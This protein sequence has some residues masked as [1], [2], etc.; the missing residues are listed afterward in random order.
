M[1]NKRV[2]LLSEGFGTGH[3]Q[4]ARALA[5]SLDAYS[6]QIET[7]VLELG[8]HQH[9]VIGP[10]ILNTYRLT[11]MSQPKLIGKLYHAKYDNS[12]GPLTQLALHRV[13]Y[14]R[15][16]RIIEEQRPD[17][18]VCTH[19]FPNMIVSRLKKAGLRVPLCTAITDYDAH[20]TWL[21]SETDAYLV[22]TEEVRKTML[23]RGVRDE[24][25][26][27]TGIPVH[28]KFH[29]S[30]DKQKIRNRFQLKNMPTVLIM[31]GGWGILKHSY[32]LLL[33]N[34][35][36]ER[37]QFVYCMGSNKKALRKMSKNPLFNHPNIHLLGYTHNIDELMDVSDLLITKP[38][39]ITCSEGLAKRI[40]MLLNNPFPGQEERNCNYFTSHGYAHR[41]ESAEQLTAWFTKLTEQCSTID[42]LKARLEQAPHYHPTK[43]LQP[44]LQFIQ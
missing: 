37:I 9:P 7:N 25:I 34:D 16:A 20:A 28:P 29:A 17:V 3:T 22:S 39:G 4:A 1:R 13:F 41:L 44:I 32:I 15:S 2:L 27:V 14:A 10:I 31:G 8:A 42:E 12:I 40:P 11:L 21:S 23:Q 19:P 38:G 30:N 26:H 33:I 43:S 18:I 5:A 35:W 6:D 24:L 36:K